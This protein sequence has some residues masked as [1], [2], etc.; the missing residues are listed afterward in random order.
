[1]GLEMGIPLPSRLGGLDSVDC[2]VRGS[3]QENFEK[4]CWNL[5]FFNS[6]GVICPNNWETA[7]RQVLEL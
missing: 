6:L 2:G 7:L 1:M 5:A 3:T 4:S